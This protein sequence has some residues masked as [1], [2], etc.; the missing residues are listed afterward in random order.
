M[1]L[2]AA[3]VWRKSPGSEYV[4]PADKVIIA[5]GQRPDSNQ[6]NL[7][8]LTVARNSTVT[9]DPL[10]LATNLPGV[11]AGGDAVTGSKNVVSAMAAGLRAAE[12]MDRYLRG[13]AL[14]IGRTLE[15]LKTVD[16]DISDKKPVRVQRAQMPA[17]SSPN[18]KAVM[19]KPVWD[20]APP[21]PKK[22]VHAVWIAP[23]AASAWSVKRFVKSRLSTIRTGFRRL[24]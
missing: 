23:G 19:P 20:S 12:S 4:V 22:R 15:P 10:T 18:E 13:Q 14:D 24:N 5:I 16:V 3:S 2:K 8:G 21:R 17:L 7:K 9:A 11:F 1:T 6:M